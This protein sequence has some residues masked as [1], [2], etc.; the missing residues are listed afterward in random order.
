MYLFIRY[1]GGIIVEGVVLAKGPNRLRVA[2]A[3]F[4]DAVD[5]KRVGAVWA[6]S[7]REEVEIDFLMSNE[8]QFQTLPCS[9]A[10]CDPAVERQAT[11]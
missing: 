11:S 3:G 4:P 1:P 2:V 6:T 10:Q 9:A 7:R 8:Y 5:L